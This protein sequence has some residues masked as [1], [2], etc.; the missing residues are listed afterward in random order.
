MGY[1][2]RVRMASFLAGAAVA[3]TAA[4][5]ILYKDFK[6]AH[7]SISH[8]MKHLHDLLDQRLS[9]LEK[10]KEAEAPREHV[11]STE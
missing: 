5:Y 11:E 8:Q 1:V 9:A 3:S 7:L 6:H 2:M 4:I 10:L